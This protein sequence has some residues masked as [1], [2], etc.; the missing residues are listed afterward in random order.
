MSSTSVQSVITDFVQPFI[1][2]GYLVNEKLDIGD[3]GGVGG[4]FRSDYSSAF[5]GGSKPFTFPH[6]DGYLSLSS[7]DFWNSLKQ[8]IPY[9]KLRAAY[10]EAG[11][12][13]GAFDRYPTIAQGNLGSQLIYTLHTTG[14]NPDL[15]VEVSK[16]FEVGTDFTIALNKGNSWLSSINA[17]FTYWKRTSENVIYAVSI[18][19]STGSTGQ[20]TNAID[21]HSNGYQFQV[22]IP[23]SQAKDFTWDFTMNFGHQT[24]IID[25]I[26]GGADI[27][28]TSFAGSTGLVLTPGQKIGQIF[29][30]KALTSVDQLRPD[31]KTPYLDPSIQGNYVIVDG[32]V[33]DPAIKNMIFTD[34]TY[35]LGDPN[36][37]FNASFIN[38]LSYKG[39]VSLGFQF[40]W[41]NGSH[42]YNQTKEWMYRDGISGDFEKPV[43]IDGQTGAY[44]AYWASAY[45]NLLL[46]AHGPGNNATKDFFYE[47]ASFVRLRNV[48]LA[49]NID[50]LLNIRHIEKLQLVL[51]GRNILTITDYTGF[52]PEIS[53]GFANSA[54]DRG[55]DH[56]TIPNLKSYQIGFNIGL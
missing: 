40:D 34:D 18:A 23:V 45:Y 36:P 26:A 13:P 39:I 31:G 52:D 49:L 10:G 16:E 43:T 42:L 41:V 27:I 3:W 35:P 11:I 32:R 47:D 51:T 5:G 56:S 20:L 9:F 54:F 17:S 2:Y 37:K 53:S 22:N 14:Q 4:G 6:V 1:T 44:T 33:V 12:Q 28:L 30:Y 25:G 46:V 7:F 55:I 29:G 8:R 48:S 21:M 24:S 38:S 50:R 15:N 19:P